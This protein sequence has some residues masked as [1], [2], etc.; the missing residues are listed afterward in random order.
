MDTTLKAFTFDELD[1]LGGKARRAEY[2]A[3]KAE[4]RLKEAGFTERPIAPILKAEPTEP[5]NKP[6]E[7]DKKAPFAQSRAKPAQKNAKKR[8]QKGP[9]K[10]APKQEKKQP[11]Q[12]ND[13][14]A[15]PAKKPASAKPAK[16]RHRA[17]K[18]ETAARSKPCRLER[19]RLKILDINHR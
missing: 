17:A 7:T 10:Q 13:A 11:E 2:I 9:P 18:A 3:A 16:R 4:G 1:V 6:A 12:K 19:S 5:S 8:Q 14:A 15:P